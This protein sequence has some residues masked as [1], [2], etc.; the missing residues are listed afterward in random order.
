MI[1]RRVVGHEVDDKA[2]AAGM[3]LGGQTVEVVERPE[4]RVHRAVVA[5]VIV[6]IAKR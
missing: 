1:A 2:H 4:D 3:E 5:D 6:E